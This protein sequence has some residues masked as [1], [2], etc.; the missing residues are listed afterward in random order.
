VLY[1]VIGAVFVTAAAAAADKKLGRQISPAFSRARNLPCSC[2]GDNT[3]C[4]MLLTIHGS[5]AAAAAAAVGRF[6]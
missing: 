1:A 3:T 4:T 2:Y 5:A 6:H